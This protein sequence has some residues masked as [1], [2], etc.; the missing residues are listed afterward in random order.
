MS[1]GKYTYEDYT[2]EDYT[3]DFELDYLGFDGIP[4]EAVSG[5]SSEKV[6]GI[7]PK[8]EADDVDGNEHAPRLRFQK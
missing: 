8:Q 2:F 1:A 4:D 6:T 5:F 3:R 7:E